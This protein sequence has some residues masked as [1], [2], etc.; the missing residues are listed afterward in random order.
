[1]NIGMLWFDNSKDNLCTKLAR[2]VSYYEK[3]YGRK[4]TH[5][6]VH[7]TT[8]IDGDCNIAIEKTRSVLPNHIWLG[9]E[10]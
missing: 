5:A 6:Y 9:M 2:A 10:D 7:P 3:K 8:K 4:P 1:M